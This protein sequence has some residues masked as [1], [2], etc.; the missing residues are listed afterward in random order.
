MEPIRIT[1]A[2][3]L[4][5]RPK[6]SDLGFG[7]VFTDHMFV[8][9]FQEGKGWYDPRV[10]PYAPFS[11]DP[12][13]AVLHYAQSVFDGLKAFRGHDG[14]VRLFRPQKHVERMNNSAKRLCIPLLDPAF[15]LES[16]KTLVGVDRD[17]V[18]RTVGTS[19]YIRPT[20]IANE[21]FLGLR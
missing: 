3:T 10:E 20:L 17:W 8:M 19:L 7:T 18:P 4:K 14:K 6:D 5:K 1:R 11:L 2:T 12:A 15:A 9:D 16:I 13:A 21:P